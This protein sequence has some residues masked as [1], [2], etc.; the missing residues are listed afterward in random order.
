[1]D[2]CSSMP[3]WQKHLSSL[4]KEALLDLQKVTNSTAPKVVYQKSEKESHYSN[5]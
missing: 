4:K 3:V 2:F 5:K 1:M